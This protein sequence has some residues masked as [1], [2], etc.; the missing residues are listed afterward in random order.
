MVYRHKVE[1]AF[2]NILNK[3][4][5]DY[6]TTPISADR[7]R[8][9]LVIVEMTQEEKD[10][11]VLSSRVSVECIILSALKKRDWE[12][13]HY[14]L[15]QKVSDAL[16]QRGSDGLHK[17]LRDLGLNVLYVFSTMDG[18]TVEMK[19]GNGS[20]VVQSSVITELQVM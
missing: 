2:A 9:P 17:K 14:T 16:S 19:D 10:H 3:A 6:V 12:E 15:L 4:G 5:V 7:K 18:G 13:V 8:Y 11:P 20:P 1:H